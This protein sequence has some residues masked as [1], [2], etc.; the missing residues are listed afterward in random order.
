M[1][2]WPGFLWTSPNTLIGIVLGLLT[3]QVPRVAH[4]ALLFDRSPRGLT[5]VMTRVNRTAMTIGFVIVSAEPVEGTLLAHERHHIRQ[6]MAWGPL[7]IP[8]YFLLAARYGYRN[9][10]M[11]RAARRAAG[12]EG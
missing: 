12:E 10:P 3:F 9:H 4:G 1:P 5:W 6:F 7:F 8:V 11:E 2:T